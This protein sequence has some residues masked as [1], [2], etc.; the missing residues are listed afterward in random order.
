MKVFEFLEATRCNQAGHTL[1]Q[2]KNLKDIRERVLS[3]AGVTVDYLKVCKYRGTMGEKT[4]Q[5]LEAASAGEGKFAIKQT[6][7]DLF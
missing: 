7:K 2:R 5:A 6:G 1:A 3:K 4:I